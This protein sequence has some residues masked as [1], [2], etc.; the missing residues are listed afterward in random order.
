MS[1][2]VHAGIKAV[3][4]DAVGTLIF[5]DPPAWAV[6]AEVARRRGV[7]PNLLALPTPMWEAFRAEEEADRAAG[8]V[9]SEEREAARWRRIV[10]DAL[11]GVPDPEACFRE[12]FDHFARPSAW[13]VNDDAAI[14]FSTL[15]RG[16]VV[17][18][19]ASNFDARLWSVLRGH[20]VLASVRDRVVISAAV[21]Y[22]KPAKQF[23]DAVVKAAGCAPE[24]IL[25]VGDHRENDYE[26]AIAAGLNAML[27]DPGGGT[28][29]DLIW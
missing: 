13:H 29:A 24:E 4:F 3:F 28:L 14:V 22:R 9:T 11:A 27:F 2:W 15:Q 23:F 6:Y 18:G 8:W 20:D 5:P 19:L 25:H 21:G 7:E 26:G 17:L 10:Y 16:G 1:C 12:L